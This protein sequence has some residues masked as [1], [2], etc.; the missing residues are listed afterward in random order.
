[1]D[2][3]KIKGKDIQDCF[4]Q[5]KMKYGPE[6]HV[7]NQRVVIEG[8]IMG[9]KLLS[10]KFYEIEIGIPE[11]QTSKDRVEK[12]LQDLKELLRQKSE[13]DTRKKSIHDLK[14]LLQDEKSYSVFKSLEKEEDAIVDTNQNQSK[15]LGL[16]IKDE[17]TKKDS[18]KN[19]ANESTYLKRL[20][21]RLISEGM[22]LDFLQELIIKTDKHL[23][24]ID[25]EKPSA[26]NDKFAGILEDRISVD[27]DLFTG[28]SRGKRKVIFF[29][30][31]TGSGKTTTVAKLAAK[32]FLHMGR[33]VSLYTTD[34]Y[35]I[36][37]IE[38]LKRYADT[39]DIPFYPVKDVK[40]LQEQLLRDGSELILVDTPGYN[41]KNQDFANRMKQ[42][43]DAFSEKD[44][45]ENI[46]ILPAT[47]S[48]SNMKSVIA[49]YESIGFKRII[50]TKI[51]EADY[52]SPV[53]ELADL[54]NKSFAYFSL[55]QEV[56]FDIVAASKK[57]LSEI[58][59]YPDKIKDLKGDTV[60]TG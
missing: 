8:G 59:V 43:K 51:D 10:K 5:M 28:T 12:K 36:A 14:P 49:A 42:Y 30:G 11:Q 17:I 2:F 9:T 23:S 54:N 41:H 58:V 55:G 20:K 18:G 45:I 50:L 57:T 13:D 22:T 7:Y 1:M 32:Y 38:Q 33:M 40:R 46:L 19:N 37:A 34:N 52:V 24:S 31:P 56:P 16:S 48:Y 35:K 26:V 25:K 15:N 53:L 44:Q 27:S 4:M 29:I 47:S 21:E 6:A 60:A 39:M 3:V